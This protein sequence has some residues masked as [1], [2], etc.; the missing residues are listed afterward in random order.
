MT[1]T[2]T[3]RATREEAAMPRSEIAE[4]AKA[5]TTPAEENDLAKEIA[6]RRRTSIVAAYQAIGMARGERPPSAVIAA[7]A[8]GRRRRFRAIGFGPPR[9]FQNSYSLPP[10][11]SALSATAFG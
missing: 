7:A 1:E 2:L 6:E 9:P 11:F 5:A 10:P 4:R 3:E 8:S